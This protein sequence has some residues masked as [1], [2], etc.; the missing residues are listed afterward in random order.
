MNVLVLEASTTAAKAMVYAASG[1]ILRLEVA[2]FTAEV[3]DVT[4]Q[5]PDGVFAQLIEVGAKAAAGLDIAAIG[6]V[7]IWHS[8]L[9]T[10]D[11]I[12]LIK[13]RTWAN[14]EASA[15]A[16][17]YRN[18]T[19][20]AA[21]HYHKTGCIPHAS[22]PLYKLINLQQQRY[23]LADTPDPL[24]KALFDPDLEIF[25]I[26]E[27]V[28]YQLTG[29]YGTS[30]NMASGTSLLSNQTRDWDKSLLQL[31]GLRV[32]QLPRLYHHSQSFPLAPAAAARL[33]LPAGLPVTLPFAD[34]CMNQLGANAF[35]PGIM[36]MS[37]GTSCAIR[38]VAN[39]LP[40][41]SIDSGLW[42]YQGLDN[43]LVGAATSGGTNC[44][45]WFRSHF[46]PGQSLK[47]L[48]AQVQ[49]SPGQPVFLPFLFGERSPGWRANR[50]GGF[51][52]HGRLY[53][54]NLL[55]DPA[56]RAELVARYGISALYSSLLEGILF[57]VYQSFKSLQEV[58]YVHT[59]N[60]SGGILHSPVWRQ[61]ASDILMREM[62]RPSTE[63]AST[64]GG[65]R[66]ALQVIDPVSY[67]IR[68]TVKRSGIDGKPTLVIAQTEEESIRPDPGRH[69]YYEERF[70]IYLEAYWGTL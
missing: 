57:A 37:V 60:L 15:T 17:A 27:Y 64:L 23:R 45:D 32:D 61:M 55:E 16:L 70:G 29:V 4:L 25:G 22:Y 59:I 53:D 8:L 30:Y 36:T 50:P 40:V 9:L 10:K 19:D 5:N 52:I 26:G 28:L 11:K 6:L 54:G 43:Y 41:L 35:V 46:S 56:V 58:V 12:P 33:N 3:N 31:A 48:D 42:C 2:P 65:A 62:H 47:E 14:P 63:Q 51:Y 24:L 34:G 67:P 18:D 21:I 1:E 13:A 66:M 20:T 39:E 69:A 44:V 68:P 38:T 7:G 49:P